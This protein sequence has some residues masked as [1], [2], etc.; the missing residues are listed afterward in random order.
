[1]GKRLLRWSSIAMGVLFG[2]YLVAALIMIFLPQPAPS[3][4][5]EALPDG[6]TNTEGNGEMVRFTMRDGTTLAA[7]YFPADSERIVLMLHGVTGS[8]EALQVPAA[9]LRETIDASVYALDLRGHGA[10]GGT[11]GDIDYVGQYEDDLADT[12]TALRDTYP[13]HE[14]IVAGY[15]MGGAI[16]LRY[17][18]Q[19]QHMV[20]GYVL[21]A[22]NMGTEAPTA[23][24]EA[25]ADL[26]PNAE[27]FLQLHIPRIIGIAMFDGMG[28]RVFN[29]L[30]TMFFNLPEPFVHTYSYRAMMNSTPADYRAS[31]EAIE[32]P[33][34]VVVGGAD[35]TMLADEFPPMVA[36]L[37]DGEVQIIPGETHSGVLYSRSLVDAIAEWMQATAPQT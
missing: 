24:T 8:S 30:P 23:R 2:V 11:R 25:P 13:D 37:S 6:T 33:L 17:A 15:S 31:F 16:T 5:R 20:D 7:R 22:P 9:L 27:P 3:A 32:V 12:I 4:A 26:D 19:K 1:M 10:S 18:A 28:V 35:E 21:I 36:E 14:L 34:L 29:G